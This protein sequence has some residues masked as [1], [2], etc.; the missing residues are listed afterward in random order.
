MLLYNLTWFD[1]ISLDVS[2]HSD[3]Y[4]LCSYL[5]SM[6]VSIEK[7]QYMIY[8]NNNIVLGDKVQLITIELAVTLMTVANLWYCEQMSS[9]GCS[10]GTLQLLRSEN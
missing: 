8:N 10:R 7:K 3:S 5:S 4:Y 1:C 9:D 6:T 2:Y